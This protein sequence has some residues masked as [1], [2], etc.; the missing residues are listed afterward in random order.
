MAD[1]ITTLHPE[2]APE[3]NLYPNVKDEN[4]PSNISRKG[5]LLWENANPFG[6]FN[7]TT[8]TVPD[9]SNY[10]AIR[11]SYRVNN[12]SSAAP[13]TEEIEYQV[14]RGATL[15]ALNQYVMHGRKITFTTPT[16]ITFDQGYSGT[17]DTEY[18]VIPV[19]IYG[20]K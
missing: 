11:F 3:D 10:K 18:A 17:T 7:P 5:D 6:T 14:G 2:G 4:I 12:G 16:S 20:I 13:V 19:S 1:V 8:I 15:Q 9:M